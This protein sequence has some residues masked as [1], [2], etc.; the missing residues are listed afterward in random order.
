M[1]GVVKDSI[2]SPLDHIVHAL[3]EGKS[4][5]RKIPACNLIVLEEYEET[6]FTLS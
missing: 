4:V 3:I 2:T 6:P 1:N 5:T